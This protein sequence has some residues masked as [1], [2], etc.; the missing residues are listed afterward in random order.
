MKKS[1]AIFA[2]LTSTLATSIR[3]QQGPAVPPPSAAATGPTMEQTV[4]FINGLLTKQGPVSSVKL[5]P[6]CELE[7]VN[8]YPFSVGNGRRIVRSVLDLAKS[9]PKSVLVEPGKYN[10]SRFDVSVGSAIYKEFPFESDPGPS[11]APGPAT[12]SVT[13]RVH[14]IQ[15]TQI[16]IASDKDNLLYTFEITKD[17]TI[18]E[19]TDFV[20]KQAGRVWK[21]SEIAIGDSAYATPGKSKNGVARA[22]DL[23]MNHPPV[24]AEQRGPRRFAP[25]GRPTSPRRSPCFPAR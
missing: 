7:E 12:D 18:R 23:I 5:H 20:A 22:E 13:G 8:V 16:V 2:L 9:D 10:S 24:E 19:P 3:A 4:D 25:C 11:R 1:I 15:G 21:F 17:T 6:P 14:A